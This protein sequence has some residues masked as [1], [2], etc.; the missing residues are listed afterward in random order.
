MKVVYKYNE[1]ITGF[2]NGEETATRQLYDMYYRP[3]CYYAEQLVNEKGEAEDIVVEVFLK[4]LKKKD[5]F[6][7]LP[8]IKSFLYKA[9]R[10]ACFDFLRKNKRKDRYNR[11]LSFITEPDELFGEKEMIA[12]KVLEVIYA[13]IENLP[14]QCKQIFKSIFMEGKTTALVAAEMGIS[15]QTVLNQKSKALQTLRLTLYKEGLY[16]AGIIF[17]YLFIITGQ[18]RS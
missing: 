18:N 13:E 15:T 17:Y 3:L 7:N 12:A 2:R 9:T 1:M 5:D 6:D 10:N 11:E 16:S 14:G 8:N 4:L